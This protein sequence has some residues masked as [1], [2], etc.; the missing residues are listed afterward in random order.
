MVCRYEKYTMSRTA[1]MSAMIGVTKWRPAA[2]SGRSNV[3][4][5]SGPYAADDSASRPSTGIPAAGPISCASAS[6]V[7]SGLPRTRSRSDMAVGDYCSQ[8]RPSGQVLASGQV[9]VDG[10]CPRPAVD[11]DRS[12]QARARPS[13]TRRW[14]EPRYAAHSR[15]SGRGVGPGRV[16]APSRAR[17][18]PCARD[19]STQCRWVY[20]QM[21]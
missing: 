18:A 15:S 6:S 11:W 1:T 7:D 21:G 14:R 9:S 4:A 13:G 20:A 16:R 12:A 17:A 8:A 3:S 5:A 2:P 10:D 19:R